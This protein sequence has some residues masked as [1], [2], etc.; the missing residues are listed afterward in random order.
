MGLIAGIVSGIIASKIIERLRVPPN[1]YICPQIANYGEGRY[2]IKIINDST[3]DAFDIDFYIR[4]IDPRTDMRFVIMGSTIPLLKGSMSKD[5]K[6][7]ENVSGIYPQLIN[8]KRIETLP[9]DDYIRQQHENKRI[10]VLDFCK[11]EKGRVI[12]QIDV[13]IIAKNVKS[14]RSMI[15]TRPLTEIVDGEWNVGERTVNPKVKSRSEG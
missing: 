1:I 14:G 13:V 4:L 5:K 8:E 9:K 15:F 2:R 10:S 7:I 11:Q 3:E 12:P 6:E